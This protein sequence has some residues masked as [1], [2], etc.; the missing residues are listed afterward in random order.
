MTDN[1]IAADGPQPGTAA[2]PR[3]VEPSFLNALPQFLPLAV[4]PLIFLALFYGGWW[5]VAPF[6]FFMLAGPLDLAFGDDE[7]NMDPAKTPERKLFWHNLPV[8]GWALLWPPT[9]IFG[10][11][12]ILAAGQFA[13]WEGIL[14]T[15]VLAVEAQAVFIVGHE[16]IHRRATWE[17]RLGE[18]LLASASYP[19][20]ATEHVYIHHAQVGTPLDVGSAPKGQSFWHYFPR[21]VASNLTGSWRVVRERLARKRLPVWH[22][23]NPFWRYGIE[24]A[25]WYGLIFWLGGLWAVLAYA[26]LC[27]GVV[28]SMKISNYM[29]HYGLRRIR[30]RS[31]RFEKV[32]PRH[33]WNANYKFSNWMF[34]NMQRHPDHHAW[35]SRPYPLLQNR[36]A[37]ESPQLPDTYAKMFNLVVRPKRWFAT[38]DPLVDRWR[39]QFYPEIEDWSAYDS[40]VS[41]ARPEAFDTIVEIYGAAPRLAGWIE[42]HPELLDSLQDREFTDLDLPKGFGPDPEAEAIA[43]RGLTRLYWTHEFGVPEM[44]ERIAEIPVQDIRDAVET[45]RNWSNDKAFQ[46]GMHTLRGNLSP[47]EA[48]V[49][50]SNLAEASISAVLSAVAAQFGDR[51]GTQADGGVAAVVLGDLASR[52]AAP[53]AALDIL[54]VHEGNTGGAYDGLCW[55]FFDAL[56]ELSHDNLIFAPIPGGRKGRAVRSLA[57]FAD[58]YRTAAPA[59]E[60]LELT[61]ARCVFEHGTPGSGQRFENARREALDAGA[62]RDTL[63]AELRESGDGAAGPDPASLEEVRGGAQHVENTARL[64]Q[65]LLAADGPE[66]PAP[67]AAAIFRAAAAK[68]RIADGA[69]AELAEA[70]TLWRNLLGALRLVADE[71]ASTKALGSKAQAVLAQSC[72]RDDFD[73]LNAAVAETATRAAAEIAALDD[74]AHDTADNA[75][76]QDAVDSAPA[77]PA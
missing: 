48:G 76:A 8:W 61:R 26:F 2:A 17:R 51:S 43:R 33:S 39:A 41:A 5:I 70:E 25:F 69:A 12:Q 45:V 28:L 63:L 15:V 4:F 58:H 18:F 27:L 46:I 52:E 1:S 6:V 19:Q 32:Q 13:V 73:T 29:Q 36:G 77:D 72:G 16:L 10:L 75:P 55:R 65:L 42:R 40:P 31:G 22:Y 20:Y 62:A 64:L 60:L 7:R 50:L 30:L 9:L 57:D 71:D 38:M 68:G 24:T 54:F 67:D 74:M 47:V 53:G 11:W 66:N 44:K 56:R 21:E 49:A 35:A 23:S 34:Y 3:P 59:S 37:D 14:L